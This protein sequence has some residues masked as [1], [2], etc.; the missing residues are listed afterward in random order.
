VRQSGNTIILTIRFIDVEK[1]TTPNTTFSSQ[2]D[3]NPHSYLMVSK[4]IPS[5]LFH[6]GI[7]IWFMAQARDFSFQST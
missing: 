5:L 6:E 1:F 2:F 3:A 4:Y 7:M